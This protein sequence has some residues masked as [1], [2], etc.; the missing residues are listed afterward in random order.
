MKSS[1][2]SESSPIDD[3]KQIVGTSGWYNCY[4]SAQGVLKHTKF[5]Y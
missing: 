2:S 5:T 3:P 4:V 1:A